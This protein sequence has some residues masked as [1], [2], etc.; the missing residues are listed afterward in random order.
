MPDLITST[1]E[2]PAFNGAAR[3]ARSALPLDAT[4]PPF[5]ILNQRSGPPLHEDPITATA[6]AK[7]ATPTFDSVLYCIVLQEKREKREKRRRFDWQSGGV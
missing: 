3:I 6:T 2:R 7:P 1:T 5:S 4:R